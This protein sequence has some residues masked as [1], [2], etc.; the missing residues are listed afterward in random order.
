MDQ[1]MHDL[2]DMNS[3]VIDIRFNGG[4]QDA[5]SF[6]ILS[7]FISGK[8]EVAT[9]QLKFGDGFTPV[10]SL[11][12]EGSENPFAGTVYVLTSPQTGSAAEAF[13]IATLAMPNVKRIGAAT[14]GAMSTAL[15]K[16]LPNGWAFSISNEVYM[17]PEGNAYENKGIPVDHDLGYPRGRQPFF[18][19]VVDDLEADKRAIME[20]I[21]SM[22]GQTADKRD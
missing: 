7:R 1:V 6:E 22:T 4:G 21:R 18:K 17:D 3:I 19:G 14:A 2:R 20:A 9:Q 15:E 12:I 11:Y 5:V 13:A 8:V 16:D 10:Q